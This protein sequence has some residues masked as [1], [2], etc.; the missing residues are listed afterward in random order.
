MIRIPYQ[1]IEG[2]FGTWFADNFN[3]ISGT[4][5]FIGFIIWRIRKQQKAKKDN[6][7]L[8]QAQKRQ[9][10][11][12]EYNDVLVLNSSKKKSSNSTQNHKPIIKGYGKRKNE[13]KWYPTGWYWDEKKQSWIPPDYHS[14]ESDK[15]WEW[16]EDKQ[17]WI[18]KE[19]K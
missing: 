14:K 4:L 16:N 2:I 5:L 10:K 18:D 15:R 12:N 8:Y 9:Q 7:W 6:D 11:R 1:F 19:K 13:P 17:I 3:T